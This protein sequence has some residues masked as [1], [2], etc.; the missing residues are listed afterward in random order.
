MGSTVLRSACT[1]RR[2]EVDS[3]Q[4]LVDQ[5]SLAMSFWLPGPHT[6]LDTWSSWR[7]D[8][9]VQLCCVLHVKIEHFFKFFINYCCLCEIYAGIAGDI[10]KV[11]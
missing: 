3:A 10:W 4:I 11:R 9:S 5:E 1:A 2:N 8:L 6:T 7:S